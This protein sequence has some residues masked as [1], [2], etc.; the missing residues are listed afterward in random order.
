MRITRKG[1]VTI[2]IAIREKAG[3]LPNTEVDFVMEDGEVK[4]VKAP[5]QK[6][7]KVSDE[8]VRHF[9]EAAKN[10]KVSDEFVR[11]F[12]EGAK[13]WKMSD[14]STDEIMEMTRD[15]KLGE[16]PAP[17]SKKYTRK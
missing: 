9:K 4:I 1:Q 8:F 13:K 16:I 6:V 7:T 17:L 3:F 15:R 5:S 12:K 2:P 14:L 11:H 10:L